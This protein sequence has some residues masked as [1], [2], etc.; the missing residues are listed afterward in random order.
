[1][2]D[3]IIPALP[4]SLN[5]CEEEIGSQQAEKAQSAD[6]NKLIL[7]CLESVYT[8]YLHRSRF[9]AERSSSRKPCWSPSLVCWFL[10]L[11]RDL[12]MCH[13]SAHTLSQEY[14][15]KTRIYPKFGELIHG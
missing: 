12:Y 3:K 6:K 11:Y 4:I 5:H 10:P 2:V 9:K 7:R 1:M 13:L 15:Y 8:L 14:K